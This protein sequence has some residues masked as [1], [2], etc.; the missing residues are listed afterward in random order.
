MTWDYVCFGTMYVSYTP[1]ILKKSHT[2][3][4]IQY[5]RITMLATCLW[6]L[7]MCSLIFYDASVLCISS[8]MHRY[9]FLYNLVSY[10]PNLLK[11][12]H[13]ATCIQYARITML[14]TCL[15]FLNMCFLIFCD[16]SVL[17]ISSC[18][19]RYFFLHN[20]SFSPCHLFP[21]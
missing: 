4:C 20:L 7:K 18:M 3:T 2:A 6:F 12:S 10:T 5:A 11:K 17:C 19:H 14:A 8:C 15:W 13:T 9:F 21:T 1:N 16:A